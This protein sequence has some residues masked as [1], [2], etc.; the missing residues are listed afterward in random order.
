MLRQGYRAP[1]QRLLLIVGFAVV[2]T[3]GAISLILIRQ[4]LTATSGVDHSLTVLNV[5]AN[6]RADLR[7]A[8]SGQRGFLLTGEAAY[9]NDYNATLGRISPAL[10]VLGKLTSDNPTQK[11]TIDRLRPLIE[12]KLGELA[13]TVTLTLQGR[14]AEALA[15]VKTDRGLSLMQ[16]IGEAYRDANAEERRLLDERRSSGTAFQ[17]ALIVVNS[18]GVLAIGGLAYASYLLFR[19]SARE[20]I[21]SERALKELNEGLEARVQ[22]RT[23]ELEAANQ[24]VQRFAYVVTHDLRSPLVNIM[25]FTSELE[26]LRDQMFQ[27]LEA[28]A[29]PSD[30]TE[31]P[32]AP[33]V[34][35]V[36]VLRKDFDEAIHFIKTSIGK[37]DGLIKAI[38]TLSRAGRRELLIQRIDLNDVLQV[39]A[40]DVEHRLR[41]AGAELVVGRLPAVRSDRM[42]LEQILS[43]LVDNAL[44]YLRDGVPGRIEVRAEETPREFRISVIDNGRGIAPADR[45]RVFD[46][47]R[48]AG[49]Q[50]KPGEGIGLAHSRGLARR[51]GGT[52]QLEEAPGGGSVFTL[53]LSKLWMARQPV[54]QGGMAA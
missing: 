25:G 29:G 41:E 23:A 33:D 20:I 15:A 51:I 28:P 32:A 47:F 1:A 13:G 3:M 5:I 53:V 46:L 44:K 52:I 21:E 43:N 48:R 6:L 4:S 8:E 35:D 7:R 19:R 10:D 30:F 37:M 54:A 14:A 38:L 50:D 24:E 39:I 22:E 49:A 2:L 16:D 12:E 27:R 11:A 18:A 26:V 9:L 40:A 17:V 34:V 45:E 36:A 31:A 42:A